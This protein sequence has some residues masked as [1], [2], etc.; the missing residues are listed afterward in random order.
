MVNLWAGRALVK[1]GKVV[2]GLM[3]ENDPRRA[4]LDRNVMWS[5][6]ELRWDRLLGNSVDVNSGGSLSEFEE[7]CFPKADAKALLSS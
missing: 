5:H 4:S 2:T 6:G 3:V 1:D 7:R